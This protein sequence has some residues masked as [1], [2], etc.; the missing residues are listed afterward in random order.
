MKRI[1]ASSKSAQSS[2]SKH[3]DKL[4]KNPLIALIWDYRINKVRQILEE[5]SEEFTQED[6]DEAFLDSAREGY[7][8]GVSL[9]LEYGADPNL[10]LDQEGKFNLTYGTNEA[11]QGILKD[12]MDSDNYQLALGEGERDWFTARKR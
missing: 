3:L 6:I 12:Y 1:A 10:A 4:V 8:P 7:M 9:L 2:Y 5:N 11:M